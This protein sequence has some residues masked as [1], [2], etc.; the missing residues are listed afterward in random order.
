MSTSGCR[1][2]AASKHR[3]QTHSELPSQ[4]LMSRT[5]VWHRA[6]DETAVERRNR[7]ETFHKTPASHPIC[8]WP[9]T[10]LNP[11]LTP[12]SSSRHERYGA[13][14]TSRGREPAGD[15]WIVTPF[16]PDS[17]LRLNVLP[18]YL[19]RGP[20]ATLAEARRQLDHAAITYSRCWVSCLGA[21]P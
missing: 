16:I 13:D 12:T 20:T 15:F 10:R 4:L 6:H 8:T 1:L 7:R 5:L 2:F 3:S 18:R 19:D 21:R 9:P 11:S 17:C 14:P